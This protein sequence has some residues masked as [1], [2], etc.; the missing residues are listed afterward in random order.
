[1]GSAIADFL[2]AWAHVRGQLTYDFIDA[3]PDERWDFSPHPSS[4]PF[5]RQARHM[6]RV[7]GVYLGGLRQARVGIEE[8]GRKREHFSGAPERAAV[9]A[10]LRE[11]DARTEQALRELE[12]REGDFSLDFFGYPR[13]LGRYLD[14]WLQ[15]ESLHHGQWHFYA[16]L[17][18]FDTPQSW[19][20]NWDL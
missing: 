11:L 9:V 18:G 5:S 4:A 13:T 3:V 17:A 20:L 2:D 6:V 12:G 19:K 7:H 16:K 1:M 8:F 14:T 15:H 10:A